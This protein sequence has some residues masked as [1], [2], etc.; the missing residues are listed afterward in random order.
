[1]EEEKL[2]H[3]VQ[4]YIESTFDSYLDNYLYKELSFLG[5][6]YE[7]NIQSIVDQLKSIE[8][9]QTEEVTKK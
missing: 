8:V 9:L 5:G 7:E 4:T 1:M 3:L 2:V 6:I